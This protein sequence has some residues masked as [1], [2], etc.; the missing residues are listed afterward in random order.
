MNKQRNEKKRRL[1]SLAHS[2][3]GEGFDI[4]K[5]LEKRAEAYDENKKNVAKAVG[6][7]PHDIDIYTNPFHYI[8]LVLE[9][10]VR[11]QP[12]GK[13]S[14]TGKDELR[15]FLKESVQGKDINSHDAKIIENKYIYYK[16]ISYK[17]SDRTISGHSQAIKLFLNDRFLEI[18]KKF[19]GER[20]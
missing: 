17:K 3:C 13:G 18:Y 14:L 7:H 1:E 12:A 5:D 4:P 16:S 2:I 20:E 9:A 6:Y 11:M 19:F 10:L 15:K 8:R